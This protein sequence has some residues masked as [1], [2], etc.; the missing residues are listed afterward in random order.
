MAPGIIVSDN[1]VDAIVTELKLLADAFKPKSDEEIVI[2]END[3]EIADAA[4]RLKS[5]REQINHI[6][7][8]LAR[9]RG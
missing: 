5:A 6:D 9:L 3:E 2:T 7:D 8:V 4:D 1:Q